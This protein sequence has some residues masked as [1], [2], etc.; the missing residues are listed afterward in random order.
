[1]RF[2]RLQQH[3]IT[4]LCSVA[5][6]TLAPSLASAQQ[7]TYYNFDTPATASPTQYS[8]SA[9]P[10]TATGAPA[11]VLFCF[12]DVDYTFGGTTPLGS[13]NPSFIADPGGST[14]YALQ[15]TPNAT[16]QSASAWFAVP[17]D[18]VDGF[19]VWFQFKIASGAADGLAFLIQNASS[20]GTDTSNSGCVNS[21]TGLTSLGY[22]YGGC[23]GYGGIKDSVALELDTYQN[24]EYGDPASPHIGLQS[25]K[26]GKPNSPSHTACGVPI[27]GNPAT[28]TFDDGGVHDV[29]IVYNGAQET[30][31]LPTISVYLDPT[32]VTGTHTPTSAPLFSGAFDITQ[33]MNTAAGGTAYIGFTAG[34]GAD[35]EQ[36]EV[37]GWTFTPH[38]TV[39]QQQPLSPPAPDGTSTTTFNFGTHSYTS[40]L[41][42]GTSTTGISMG[43]IANTI[44]PTNFTALLGLGATQ[45]TGSACQVYDDTGGNCIIYS[46]YCYDTTSK[47]V[48]ACP[49]PVNPP[50]D[51]LSDPSPADCVTLTS[52]YNNS[53]QPISPGYLQGDPLYSPITSINGNGTTATVACTGECAVI[54]GQTVTILGNSG[55]Y[56][57]TVTVQTVPSA[58]QFTFLSSAS[59]TGTGGFLNLKQRAGYLHVVHPA[60]SRRLHDWKDQKLLR[61]C[62]TLLYCRSEPDAT[63]SGNQQSGAEPGGRSHRHHHRNHER[64]A[65]QSVRSAVSIQPRR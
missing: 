31:N 17:Q 19:N 23:I 26:A 14:N 47:Q 37:M 45:Y 50:A 30:S 18:V 8:T 24:S 55:A 36:N 38:A 53:I 40:N 48:E 59:G 57:G 7:V 63:L 3:L 49:A 34:T 5:F 21:G 46:V 9:N 15:M 52:A 60:E 25:C 28:P 1:M 43:V 51:C 58:S 54:A 27:A 61:F 44:S 42:S 6:A 41:P 4:A 56:N 22:G 11:N 10:C 29:V 2:P 35:S 64:R 20:T 62:R 39:S 65:E 13:P 32:Y 33:Y 16:N 12:N